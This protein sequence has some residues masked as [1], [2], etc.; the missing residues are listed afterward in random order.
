M[1][2][3][4]LILI[5]GLLS[6]GSLQA[7]PIVAY[8]VT[9]LGISGIISVTPP[10]VLDAVP[11]AGSG[12][13]QV[14][15][16]AYLNGAYY[17]AEAFGNALF[18]VDPLDSSQTIVGNGG[19]LEYKEF[20]S[21]TTALYGIDTTGILSSI[22]PRSGETHLIGQTGLEHLRQVQALSSGAGTLYFS[23]DTNLYAINTA[24]GALTL[25][26]NTGG[27]TIQALGFVSGSLY[28]I[29]PSGDVDILDNHHRCR[30]KNRCN[31]RG[32]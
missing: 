17:E 11:I 5:V 4:P 10:E 18:K 3:Q 15:G 32:C 7:G 14:A 6:A 26:G 8:A 23:S 13:F 29:T 20:G 19:P 2:N 21:T 28:G 22:D 27:D 12:S 30:H 25:I 24:T 1:K 9:D 31:L 16:L